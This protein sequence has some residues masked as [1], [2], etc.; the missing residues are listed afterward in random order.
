[1]S[2]ITTSLLYLRRQNQI[3]E[4]HIMQ[5]PIHS[6]YLQLTK[7]NIFYNI[8]TWFDSHKSSGT[9]SMSEKILKHLQND[10]S[11][12]LSD[13]FGVFFDWTFLS[14]QKIAKVIPI[15]KNNLK[16]IIQIININT[17][18]S[19]IL[20]RSLRNLCTQNSL[21]LWILKIWFS[22]QLGFGK[23]TDYLHFD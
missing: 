19:N 5:T 13:V 11:W 9:N 12:Q 22:L 10:I 4:A 2:S 14:V 17:L 18:L 1:M 16:L 21:I 20:K 7:W 8:F 6:S 15:H 23:N 3:S